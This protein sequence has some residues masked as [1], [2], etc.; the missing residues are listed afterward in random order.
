M[1]FAELKKKNENLQIYKKPKIKPKMI[2]AEFKKN[3]E[4]LQIYKKTKNEFCRI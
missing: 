4:N 2:V 1:N 3:N